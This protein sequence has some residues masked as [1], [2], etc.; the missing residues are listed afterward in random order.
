MRVSPAGPH[1]F[2]LSP[3]LGFSFFFSLLVMPLF[4]FFMRRPVRIAECRAPSRMILK[5]ERGR[6]LVTIFY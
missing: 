2:A 6:R 3:F 1:P 5:D 4:I